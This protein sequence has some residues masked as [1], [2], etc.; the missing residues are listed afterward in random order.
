MAQGPFFSIV[1]PT[2]NRAEK[3]R[4]ALD[5]IAQ[6]TFKNSELIVCDDGSFD[7]TAEVVESFSQKIN[8][9]YL[10]NENSGGPARPRNNGLRHARG[11]WVCFLDADDWWYPEKLQQVS[12]LVQ[13][14]DV[15]YHHTNIYAPH[16]KKLRLMN[17]RQ[18]K[19]PVFVDLMTKG[20][21]LIT[22]SVCVRKSILDQAGGFSEEAALT[23][24]EDFD[25]WLRIARITDRFV[26]I[27]KCLGAYWVDDENISTYSDRAITR[28]KELHARY[29]GYLRPA[30]RLESERLLSYK[31]GLAK[32]HMGLY[33]ESAS[34]FRESLKSG[35]TKRK[36]YSLLQLALLYARK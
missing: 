14:A 15:I 9:N 12:T 23:A 6:Q 7:D 25:L 18:L 17:V 31:I 27:N 11:E 16:G 1:I 8:I 10:W 22:S 28:E 5:S 34:Y 19:P 35:C 30:E 36:L 33:R 2:Y 20:S 4:R 24:I 21:A 29:Q 26:R 13:D 3:L 32:K